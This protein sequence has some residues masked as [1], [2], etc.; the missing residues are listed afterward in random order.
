VPQPM[1]LFSILEL[2]VY[3]RIVLIGSD[4]VQGLYCRVGSSCLLRLGEGRFVMLKSVG[5]AELFSRV[6]ARRG[7]M[8]LHSWVVPGAESG[9]WGIIG[10]PTRQYPRGRNSSQMAYLEER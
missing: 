10:R 9:Q 3:R 5:G 6:P 8:G 1:W 4:E 2:S 7:S